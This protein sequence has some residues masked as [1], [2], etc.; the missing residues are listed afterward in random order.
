MRR[1]NSFFPSFPKKKKR[2]PVGPFLFF[3]RSGMESELGHQL[4]FSQRNH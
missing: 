2:P 4:P 1:R 3:S